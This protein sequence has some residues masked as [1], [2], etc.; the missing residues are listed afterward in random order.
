MAQ[1]VTHGKKAKIWMARPSAPTVLIEITNRAYGVRLAFERDLA[2]ASVFGLGDK[3]FTGGMRGATTSIDIR[4]A[5]DID[6][7]LFECYQSD[8]PVLIRYAPEGNATGKR[9][10]EGYFLLGQYEPGSNIGDNN[11]G[12]TNFTRT[13]GSTRG[14]FA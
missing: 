4:Q 9:Y 8:E 12:T 2:D 6:Q 10:Y 11:N 13:A 1:D 3:E 14:I 5:D 7:I